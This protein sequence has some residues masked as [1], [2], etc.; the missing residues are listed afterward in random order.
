MVK[1][2]FTVQRLN[3]YLFLHTVEAYNDS[4]LRDFFMPQQSISTP[5]SWRLLLLKSSS[6]R[7]DIGGRAIDNIAQP[8][9]VILQSFNL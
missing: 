1:V 9:S 3:V 8:L 2:L 5:E 6:L 4:P 7:L